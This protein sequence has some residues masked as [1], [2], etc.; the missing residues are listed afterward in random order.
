MRRAGVGGMAEERR[1][2]E[3]LLG[4]LQQRVMVEDRL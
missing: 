1:E 2:P 3:E 4:R